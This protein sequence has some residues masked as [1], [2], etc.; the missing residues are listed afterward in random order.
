MNRLTVFLAGIVVGAVGLYTSENFYIVR[1]NESFHLIPKIAAKLEIPYRDIRNYSP[2]D[3]QA[4][5]SLALSIYKS[6]KEELIVESGVSSMQAQ[7]Q[8]LL[9]SFGS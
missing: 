8:N 4:D 2:E 5:T 6:Q 7:L 3:W 9:K 1:S